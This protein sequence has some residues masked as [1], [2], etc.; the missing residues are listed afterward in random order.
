MTISKDMIAI[1]DYEMGN[2]KSASKALEA[3]GGEV[4]IT[5]DPKVAL[6]AD[7]LVVPG[8]GAFRDCM[9][10][11]RKFKLDE[12]IGDFIRSGRPYLGICLGMQILMDESEEGGTFPGLGI[13]S[14]KVIRFA[15]E[16]NLK[17][18][19]MGW[20]RLDPEK[21]SRILQGLKPEAFAYFVH[22][23]YVT[24]TKKK[25]SAAS[26]E[27]GV[28]FTSVIEQDNVYAVQFHPEKSQA[29][30]LKILENF[31]KRT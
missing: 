2:L 12:A 10:A 14:G 21:D 17:V 29:V 22:S 8:V 23:Y 3:V 16:L 18:P 28:K 20:N 26:T 5:R 1:L 19:H 31:V 27:Y 30:G 13:F 4:R 24:P 9:A 6:Q 15:P 11:L 25:I 7:K